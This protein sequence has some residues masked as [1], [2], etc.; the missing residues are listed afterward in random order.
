MQPVWGTNGY[1]VQTFFC[2]QQFIYIIIATRPKIGGHLIGLFLYH[3]TYRNQFPLIE[4][5][6]DI[7]LCYSSAADDAKPNWT[8]L[9]LAVIF[10]GKKLR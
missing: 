1:H 3:I 5:V 6:F 4:D 8:L 9:M 10:A 2:L 7:S